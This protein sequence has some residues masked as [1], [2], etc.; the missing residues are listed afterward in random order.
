MKRNRPFDW[1]CHRLRR[2]LWKW[3][4]LIILAVL[5]VL[6]VMVWT[7]ESYGA[8]PKDFLQGGVMVSQ[9]F[10]AEKGDELVRV[11]KVQ[12]T[13]GVYICFGVINGDKGYYVL[14]TADG[15]IVSIYEN[16]QEKPKKVWDR[17]WR[18]I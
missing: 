8:E 7:G 17:K 16:H 5:L 18:S 2:F 13:D 6:P 12:P 3:K 15:G 4:L 9:G 1:G 14:I 11:D 10:C